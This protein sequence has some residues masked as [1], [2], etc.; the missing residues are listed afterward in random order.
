MLLFFIAEMFNLSDFSYDPALELA[1]NF[2]EFLHDSI[3]AVKFTGV[4]VGSLLALCVSLLSLKM[5]KNDKIII[6]IIT[7]VGIFQ[8]GPLIPHPLNK[9]LISA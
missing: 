5:D 9:Y 1:E 7:I 3:Q 2:T 6:T 4:S 8:G